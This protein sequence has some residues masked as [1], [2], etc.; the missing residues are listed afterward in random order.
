MFSP[1]LKRGPDGVLAGAPFF[2]GPEIMGGAFIQLSSDSETPFVGMYSAAAAA[3]GLL[4]ASLD[5]SFA[6]S[7]SFSLESQLGN[8]RWVPGGSG[9]IVLVGAT[10]GAAV[11]F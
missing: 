7:R 4:G 3:R 1:T 9:T 10:L 8:L 11:R 5:L 6:L 2:I